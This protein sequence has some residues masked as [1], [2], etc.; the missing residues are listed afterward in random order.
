MHI[1]A[2]ASWMKDGEPTLSWKEDQYQGRYY[3]LLEQHR[4]HVLLQVVGHEHYVD[5]GYHAAEAGGFYLPSIYFPSLTSNRGVA[6]AGFGTFVYEDTDATLDQLKFTFIDVAATVGLPQ[7]TT[8]D[9]LP[10]TE[11]DFTT[12]YDFK[13]LSADGI[14]EFVG[15]MQETPELA[16]KFM[17][18]RFGFE[19]GT[20]AD[21]DLLQ[22]GLDAYKGFHLI[23]QD[24]TL[25]D[26]FLRKAD[27]GTQVC[28]MS[29]SLTVEEL[30]TCVAT[31]K[32]QENDSAFTGAAVQ[33]ALLS[34]MVLVLA[35]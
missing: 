13:N 15:R 1:F 19:T 30:G 3:S 18:N 16:R 6:R 4:H 8:Y 22:I 17:F 32:N 7:T 20:E 21:Q 25:E 31:A 5:L 2:S 27:F 28:V 35:A 33:A 23:G 14:A 26:A 12:E 11:I 34:A 10:W 24:A 29:K 9:A